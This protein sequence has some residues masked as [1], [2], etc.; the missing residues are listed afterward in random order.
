LTRRTGDKQLQ[1]GDETSHTDAVC[2]LKYEL[3]MLATKRLSDS[4][5]PDND[6]ATLFVAHWLKLS[7]A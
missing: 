4:A 5:K 7:T 6:Q 1:F 3:Q 2:I